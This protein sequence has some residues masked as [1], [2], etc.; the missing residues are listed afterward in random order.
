MKPER[1]SRERRPA[2]STRRNGIVRIFRESVQRRVK[3]GVRILWRVL[4]GKI[5]ERYIMFA[6]RYATSCT[7]TIVLRINNTINQ[8]FEGTNNRICGKFFAPLKRPVN[9]IVMSLRSSRSE[10]CR[11]C[12]TSTLFQDLEWMKKKKKKKKR[13]TYKCWNILCVQIKLFRNDTPHCIVIKNKEI[14]R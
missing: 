10:F 1:R 4:N 12:R 3:R 9:L 14:H 5:K 7:A 11:G 2:S 8:T 13:S 6:E